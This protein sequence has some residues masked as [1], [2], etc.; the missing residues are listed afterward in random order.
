M[1]PGTPGDILTPVLGQGK[2]NLS[3]QQLTGS[4]SRNCSENSGG[5]SK[6]AGFEQ[7]N[8]DTGV[9]RMCGTTSR[10]HPQ[11]VMP[12]RYLCR[13]PEIEKDRQAAAEKAVS[14]EDFQG[15]WKACSS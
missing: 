4:Q 7:Q 8:D 9:A 11:A 15:E 3:L 1:E 5:M 2:Y 10:G 12:D 6:G 14:K 13:D